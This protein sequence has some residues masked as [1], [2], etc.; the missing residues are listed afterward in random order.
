MATPSV[1]PQP[2]APVPRRGNPLHRRSDSL[3]FWVRVVF[4]AA[5]A[6]AAALTVLLGL[7]LYADGR[8]EAARQASGLERVDAVD[9]TAPVAAGVDT[10]VA[11]LT[12]HDASGSHRAQAPV[13]PA[14][15]PGDHVPLYVDAKGIPQPDPI[16]AVQSAGSAA[17]YSLAIFSGAVLLL[18]GGYAF[19][20]HRIDA[21]AWKSWESEWAKVEPEWTHRR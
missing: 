14:T 13:P 5:L 2:S 3:R 21:S 7:H 15:A 8:A 17:T 20:R 19:S 4:A 11:T 18:S 12:W 6:V 1:A 10:W 16:P 9:A